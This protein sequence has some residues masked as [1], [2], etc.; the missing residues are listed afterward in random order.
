MAGS[1]AGAPLFP[2]KTAAETFQI[3]K[4]PSF[5]IPISFP[6]PSIGDESER[7]GPGGE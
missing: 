4:L 7:G 5:P 6:F 1:V 2:S 3:L